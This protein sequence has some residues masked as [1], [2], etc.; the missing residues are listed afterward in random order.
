MLKMNIKPP[1]PRD[2]LNLE[3]IT[4]PLKEKTKPYS[5]VLIIESKD[6][7]DPFRSW[8]CE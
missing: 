3:P 1:T 2:R 8:L 5:R 6:E 7:K 4:F